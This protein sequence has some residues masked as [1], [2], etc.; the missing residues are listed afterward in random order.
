MQIN[1]KSIRTPQRYLY[2]LHPGDKFYVATPLSDEDLQKLQPYGIAPGKPARIP[3]PQRSATQVNANGKWVILRDLP[4]K[5]RVFARTYHLKTYQG[6]DIYGTCYQARMCYQRKLIPPTELAFV[7]ED[8]TLYSPLLENSEDDMQRI[9]AAMNVVLEMLGHCEIWTAERAPALPPVNQ[10][11]VPWEILRA[12]TRE[13]MEWRHYLE[14]TTERKADAQ[15]VE[16]YKRHETVMDR[17]PEFVV[18]G[19]QNFFG[20]VVYG[21]PTLNLFIFESNEINNAT[22]AFRGNWEAAS[23]LTKTEILAGGLQE[24]RIFH[25]AQWQEN[26]GKLFFRFSREV[27]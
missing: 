1:R 27:A 8:G 13:R 12:G 23:K 10:M 18:I 5:I 16:L 3:T 2:A 14:K 7:I 9:K 17:K 25:T 6:D 19:K 15:K 4:K 11:E 26:L 22:Y 21:F 20:Y 24:A